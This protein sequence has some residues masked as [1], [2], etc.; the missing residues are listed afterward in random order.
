MSRWIIG[1]VLLKPTYFPCYNSFDQ[2]QRKAFISYK[3]IKSKFPNK[4]NLPKFWNYTSGRHFPPTL[5]STETFIVLSYAFVSMI[6]LDFLADVGCHFSIK[7]SIKISSFYGKWSDIRQVVAWST[8]NLFLLLWLYIRNI[9]PA[10]N[11]ATPQRSYAT[12]KISVRM[13]ETRHDRIFGEAFSDCDFDGCSSGGSFFVGFTLVIPM[14]C[15]LL[16][17]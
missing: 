10:C 17:L 15:K 16:R 14:M 7:F 12:I 3:K 4:R 6:S 11:N 5:L 8:G 1:W 2:R 13:K 9:V